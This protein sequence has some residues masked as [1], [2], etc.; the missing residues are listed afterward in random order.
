MLPDPLERLNDAFT[1][2]YAIERELAEGGM[3]TVYIAD[4]LKLHRKVAIKVLRP[5]LSSVSA[6][7][8]F[9]REIA[10]VANLHHP[11]IVPLY[12]SGEVD[13]RPFYVMP[14]IEGESLRAKLQRE[15]QI[16]V[17]EALSITRQIASALD[18]AHAQ[19][20]VHRDVKPEN[21]MLHM[22]DAM[23][24]D[25]GVALA[26]SA[27]YGERLTAT[28]VALGTPHYMSPE[29]AAGEPDL[30]ARSDVY[31][32]ACVLYELL[33]GEPPYTG[34]TVQAVM[35]K[36]F[37]TPAPPVRRVRPIVSAAVEQALLKALS[38][39]PAD[40]F[41]SCGAFVEAF[42]HPATSQRRIPS[43]AVLPFRNLSSDPANEFF[44]DG[45]TEDVI[46]QLCKIRSLKVISRAS[47]MR[48]K[49]RE[50]SLGEIGAMLGVATLLEGSVRRVGDQV[51][52]VAELVDAEG[53]QQLWAETYDR[54]LTDI[55]AIQ[56]DVA[57]KI[58]TALQA[59]LLP[60]ERV[61]IRHGPTT[62][63]HAYQ[64]YLQGRLYYSRYTED[65]IQKGI[66]YYQQAI[67]ADPNYALP[68]VGVALAYAELVVGQGGGAVK[69]GEA[70]R[71][72]REAVTTALA[73]DNDLGDA[74]AVLALLKFV[75]DYDWAGAEDEF[76]LALN[77][78][79]G[80]ADIYDHYGWL[81]AALGRIEEAL[82]L[83]RRAQELDPMVHRTDVASTLLRAGRWQEALQAAL[84]AI[85]FEPE[86]S[87]GRS[88]LGWAYLEMG[89]VDEGLTNLEHAVA[90][91]PNNTMS[92]AQ[93]GQ[94]YAM[95]GKVG[96]ARE[97]LRRLEQLSRE[98]YVSPYHMAY[99]HTG[100]GNIDRAMDFLEQAVDE[101]A[102]AVYGIKGSFLFK[103]LQSHPRF[104]AL[105][106]RMNLN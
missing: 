18:Y 92:L 25:F 78:S 61:R 32:L 49:N 70:Y 37:T 5:E 48:F 19:R 35:A 13:G 96:A 43:V 59:E 16:A 55:F 57:L 1:G 79:P 66:K 51:R 71:Q 67:A 83:V 102:G 47:A 58:T 65:S 90:I 22:G 14:F 21:I 62:D 33:T 103:P 15:K 45:V 95:F 86:Y 99:I 23:V 68:Y 84:R 46:A 24:T 36:R 81:C 91:D 89:M 93:L 100:L 41:A 97:I 28:G 7:D 31:S 106:S 42:N 77:L 10:I 8:R 69:P 80:S 6:S 17:D 11:H 39:A 40:R 94:A 56:T 4:D 9:A 20:L 3:A 50:R 76:K 104:I 85:D 54:Q 44:A 63:I 98:R 2:R 12:D 75:H 87:R 64:S 27:V 73:L 82:A 30:D 26:A 38:N 72:A 74:H 88:T 34:A 52:I 101:R 105:L 53:E 29:Q 60:E